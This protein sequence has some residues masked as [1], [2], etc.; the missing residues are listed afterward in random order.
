MD[1]A[2][3]LHNL[4][5]ARHEDIAA[6]IK[7]QAFALLGKDRP[8]ERWPATDERRVRHEA[9][10][11]LHYALRKYRRRWDQPTRPLTR[12]LVLGESYVRASFL[13]VCDGLLECLSY[14][15]LDG[16]VGE[17]LKVRGTLPRSW[18]FLYLRDILERVVANDPQKQLEA[19]DKALARAI[20]GGIRFTLHRFFTQ[21]N[22]SDVI[23]QYDVKVD[24][25][26]IGFTIA[27]ELS[28][29]QQ[30]RDVAGPEFLKVCRNPG[31]W[32]PREPVFAQKW[33]AEGRRA[34]LPPI[35][36]DTEKETVNTSSSELE[37]NV[38]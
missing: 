21:V 11:G 35:K 15:C 30:A 22:F 14:L 25:S 28:Y 26:R 4:L 24:A 5:M 9:L 33:M 2:L 8:K 12:K 29:L 19:S 16:P 3:A 36:P 34:G 18:H 10:M 23:G 6:D 7:S 27:E 1:M 13:A 38:A 32:E 31:M 17:V 20:P 37:L